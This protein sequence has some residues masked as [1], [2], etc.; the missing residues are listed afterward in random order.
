MEQIDFKLH[1][2]PLFSQFSDDMMGEVIAELKEKILQKDDILF[3]QGDSGEELYIVKSGSIAIFSPS[4]Q[5][6]TKGQAIRV[7]KKGDM[8]GEMAILDQK[9]R[10]ASARAEEDSIVLALNGKKFQ[11]MMDDNFALSLGV[12][13]GLSDR[14]RYTT[15]FLEKVKYW[16]GKM[17]VGDY[18]SVSG[19]SEVEKFQDKSLD[20]L[21][22][23]FAKMAANIKAREDKLRQEVVELRIEIDE[24]K[25]QQEARSIMDTDLFKELRIKA[26]QMRDMDDD[27]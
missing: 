2:V 10:S 18:Q 12:M 20:S 27:E 15:D 9:N 11:R 16:V 21:A 3:N 13:R 6:K 26:K 8:L 19:S 23:E 7:F 14:I 24:V 4:S 25:R 1:D 22:V 5:D 17:T